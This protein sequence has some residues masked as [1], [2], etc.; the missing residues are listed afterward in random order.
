MMSSAE[1]LVAEQAEDQG[2][3]F[4]A[5]TAPEAYL[6]QELR[7]LHAAVEADAAIKKEPAVGFVVVPTI[8]TVFDPA[9]DTK[10]PA[11]T[12]QETFCSQCGGE[13]GP[14]NHGFSHCEHHKHL[15]RI[16]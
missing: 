2:L 9:L 7:R 4:I 13:F 3:W 6:Q 16:D 10:P 14:G 1:R 8:R 5:Q 15:R 12:L 11:Y